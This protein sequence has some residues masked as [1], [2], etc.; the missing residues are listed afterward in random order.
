MAITYF[1]KAVH[2]A[3][4]GSNATNQITLTPP[5]SMQADDYVLVYMHQRAVGGGAA[6][7]MTIGVTGGQSWTSEGDWASANTNFS[8]LHHCRYNGTW[9]ANPRFDSSSSACDS[10]L[11]LVFRGVHTTSAIDVAVARS[12]NSAPGSPFDCSVAALN[13]VNS[14]AVAVVF[15]GSQDDNTYVLQTGGGWTNPDSVAMWRNTA[16]N[17]ISIS[18]AYLITSSSG[19][20]GAVVNRQTV[21]GG[22]AWQ[23]HSIAL[24]PAG[25][26][27]V[28]RKRH[29]MMI[30]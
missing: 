13:I 15:W 23:S 17:D 30:Y 29:T 9:S 8:H 18:A 24:K 1:G 10:A 27:A 5:G 7:D 26:A 16:G 14:G 12:D 22:D 19:S 4:N 2:P 21:N 3:D 25:A 6:D 11:M 28:P 20:T